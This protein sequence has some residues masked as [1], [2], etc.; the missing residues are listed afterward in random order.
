MIQLGSDLNFNQTGGGGKSPRWL[1]TPL[2]FSIFNQTLPNF[3]TLSKIYLDVT[4]ANAIL[5]GIFSQICNFRVSINE[6]DLKQLV[7][8]FYGF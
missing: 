7:S 5:T 4:M 8:P 6:K 2:T 1:W 3:A